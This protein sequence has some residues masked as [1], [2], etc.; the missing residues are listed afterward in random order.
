MTAK[1]QGLFKNHGN[2]KTIIDEDHAR[3]SVPDPLICDINHF[4]N[5]YST[6]LF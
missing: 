4:F 5:K 3:K 6:I 2:R 1:I